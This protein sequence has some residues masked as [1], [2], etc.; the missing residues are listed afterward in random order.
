MTPKTEILKSKFLL[1]YLKFLSNLF[2][3]VLIEKSSL[4]GGLVAIFYFPIQLGIS[5]IPID[6]IIFFR[7]VAK[8]HQPVI[9]CLALL[10]LMSHVPCSTLATNSLP[11]TQKAVDDPVKVPNLLFLV[12]IEKSSHF[13]FFELGFHPPDVPRST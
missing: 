7:G 6:E 5:I 11:D 13:F 10:D 2:F 12:L 3:L 9:L 1:N 8:N 4:V